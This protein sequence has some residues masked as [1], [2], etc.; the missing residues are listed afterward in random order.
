MQ[1]CRMGRRPS[2]PE[3]SHREVIQDADEQALAPT[4]ELSPIVSLD[5]MIVNSVLERMKPSNNWVT[6]DHSVEVE[7]SFEIVEKS[8]FNNSTMLGSIAL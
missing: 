4:C 8:S 7:H 3:I 6:Q 5:D 1:G 2:L